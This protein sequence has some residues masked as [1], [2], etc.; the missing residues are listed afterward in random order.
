MPRK[1]ILPGQMITPEKLQRAR[2]LRS[3]M[4]PAERLLW[5]ASRG[6]KLDGLHFRR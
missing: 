2:E 1:N 6:N 3:G 4:T 5:Q